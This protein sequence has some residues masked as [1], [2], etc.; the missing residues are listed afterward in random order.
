MKSKVVLVAFL[1][2]LYIAPMIFL[3]ALSTEYEISDESITS[4]KGTLP[5]DVLF[6]PDSIDSNIYFG[7]SGDSGFENTFE[8][9]GVFFTVTDGDDKDIHFVCNE[10]DILIE[11]FE[12]A[13][14]GYE[15]DDDANSKY[16]QYPGWTQ[17]IFFTVT[18]SFHNGTIV[19]SGGLHGISNNYTLTLKFSADSGA[20]LYVDYVQIRFTYMT[21]SDADHYAESFGDV[22]DWTTSDVSISS[23]DDVATITEN[24]AGS[25]GRTYASFSSIDFFEYYYEF[26]IELMTA[27]TANLEFYDGSD[28]NTLKTF[29]AAG[30]YKGIISDTD[31]AT[32][33]RIG[34]FVGSEGGNIKPDYLRV[35]NSSEMGFQHDG[36]TTAGVTN[37][38]DAGVTYSASTDGDILT[39]F[40]KRTQAGDTVAYFFIAYDTTAT[41][42][43][44]ERDYYPFFEA[45]VNATIAGGATYV[46]MVPYLDGY[47]AVTALVEDGSF[48]TIRKNTLAFT[49]TESNM[50]VAFYSRLDS[51]GANFTVELD[52]AKYYSIAGFSVTQSGVTIEDYLYVDSG[53]LYSNIDSGYIETNY[54]PALSIVTGVNSIWILTTSSGTPESDYY[55]SAWAGYSSETE[56]SLANGT[57]TD[58]KLKFTDDANVAA[59]TLFIAPPQWYESGKVELLFT[60]PLDE[61]GLDML[62]IFLGLIMIPLS[63]LYL[64]K[65][66]RSE[67]SSEK[68]FYGLIAFVIGWALFLGGIMP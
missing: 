37:D 67:M 40:A 13:I 65:G 35:G 50:F 66:G 25:T 54:D 45:S 59:L 12:Y 57:L 16:Y 42:I 30:T 15:V 36:S 47:Y 28:Y 9:D 31:A 4:F 24:G 51:V 3:S 46:N 68:L 33:Q 5:D 56:G 8:K 38:A 14:Y 63:T 17:F 7:D 64:V 27:T 52:Y 10:T 43:D 61:T 62:L 48:E 53:V 26:R 49:L 6:Y 55:V 11:K 1:L 44:I 32:M 41:S 23:D 22:S 29:T 19:L 39:L 18:P 60:V 2:M 34:F 21:L 20:T 58:L